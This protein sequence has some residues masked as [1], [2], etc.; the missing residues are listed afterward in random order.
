MSLFQLFTILRARRGLAGLI[1]LGTIALALVWVV[2]RPANFTARAPVLM[3]VRTD[4]VGMTSQ[5]NPVVTPAFMS[6]QI[7]IVK[8]ERVAERAFDAA[9]GPAAAVE[10]ARGSARTSPRRRTG[11]PD[12]CSSGWRS[13]RRARA[14]SST[15]P[16]P[17]AARPRRPAWPMPS[18]R[19]T[20]KS[21]WNCEPNRPRNMP[22]FSKSRSRLQ[23][24]SWRTP[25]PSCPPSSSS[26]AS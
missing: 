3:D 12:S 14:T 18:R 21:A 1:V 10:V 8:S 25:M 24:T 2:L 23:G 20:W 16:G 7:D 17:G 15:S 9:G 26:R 4:P 6:T 5:Y 22:D 13:S 11:S 19:P